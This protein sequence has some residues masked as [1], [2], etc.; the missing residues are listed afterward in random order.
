V[1]TRWLDE[2]GGPLPEGLD[3]YGFTGRLAKVDKEQS[4]AVNPDDTLSYIAHFSI[5]T[6]CKRQVFQVPDAS[7]LG[8]YYIHVNG[9]STY[10][11][12]RFA[13]QSLPKA[14]TDTDESP[15][16]QRPAR[17]VPFQVRTKTNGEYKTQ[18]RPEMEFSVYDIEVE[19][20]SVVE[21]GSDPE[22][23]YD[24]AVEVIYTIFD[25]AN[26][27]QLETFGGDRELVISVEDGG[28]EIIWP[29]EEGADPKTVW[30]EL[31]SALS[32]ED[33]QAIQIYQTGDEENILWEETLGGRIF[34]EK[35]NKAA[36]PPGDEAV[37]VSDFLPTKDYSDEVE[38]KIEKLS[39]GVIAKILPLTSGVGERFSKAELTVAEE[40][41][42]G[43]VKVTA[44]RWNDKAQTWVTAHKTIP[45]KCACTPC[46]KV[47][48][49]KESHV[50]SL[51][52]ELGLGN[53]TGGVSAGSIALEAESLSTDMDLRQLIRLKYQADNTKQLTG[54][55]EQTQQPYVKQVTSD[56]TFVDI[57]PID[58]NNVD[59]IF[60]E[61]EAR[62]D[63][64]NA[65]GVYETKA[66]ATPIKTWHVS[67]ASQGNTQYLTMT[68]ASGEGADNYVFSQSGTQTEP[69]WTLNKGNGKQVTTR[70]EVIVPGVSRTVTETIS[71]KSGAT[72]SVKIEK[73]EIFPW[74]ESIVETVE[75]PEGTAQKTTT[76]YC[77]A[78]DGQGCLYG[79][80]KHRINPDGSWV[81]YTYTAVNGR[82]DYGMKVMETSGLLDQDN[83]EANPS[84]VKAVSYDYTP[85]TD[86]EK[87]QDYK[88]R[89]RT[90]TV[91]EAG[92][93][94]SRTYYV[95]QGNPA[96]EH[97]EIVEQAWSPSAGYGDD[98]NQRTVRTYYPVNYED[99]S[100][101]SSGLLKSVQYPDGKMDTYRYQTEGEGRIETVTHGTATSP[102]GVPYKTT[103][104]VTTYDKYENAVRQETRVYTGNSYHALSWVVTAYDDAGRVLSTQQSDGLTTETEWGCCGKTYEMNA[105]GQ[106][107]TYEYD[108]LK[109]TVQ[110][111]SDRGT[112][113]ITTTYTLDAVGRQLA[114]KVTSGGLTQTTSNQYDQAGRL[115]STTGPDG[116]TTTYGYPDP[117]TTIVTRPGGAEEIT[118]RYI[119]GRTKSV[120]GTGVTPRYYE[121][122]TNADG[123]KTTTVYTGSENSP[124]WERTTTDM[125]GRTIKTEAPGYQGA[126]QVTE[127]FYDDKGRLV[128]TTAP[129]SA[130]TIYEYDELGN[131]TGGGLDV[132]GDQNLTEN[133][134][135]RL[136]RTDTMYVQMAGAWWQ[137]TV[138]AVYDDDN[139]E[140]IT[141]VQRARMSG[142]TGGLVSET[143]SV[144]IFGNETST[145]KYVSQATKTEQT[146][147][148]YPDSIVDATSTTEACSPQAQARPGSRRHL[149]TTP[150]VV[151]RQSQ[152]QEPEPQRP[153]TI[154]KDNSP[155]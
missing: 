91:T 92:Q 15:L 62:S 151:E 146:I 63:D 41:E 140:I 79:Q 141:G 145:R 35:K 136:S 105:N 16:E 39:K 56:Q 116:L 25:D 108:E 102:K 26:N 117:L 101:P 53:T 121:Y 24:N 74:G 59:I 80:V 19:E 103:Q 10:E 31:M 122:A 130:D 81:K 70:Q 22:S 106:E 29:P 96:L 17:F 124:V 45:V 154:P 7:S 138:G 113:R 42:N 6:G 69:T 137:E 86:D 1:H 149:D 14:E 54:E 132:S 152:I 139:K 57:K 4:N 99:R 21:N 23:P 82:D 111:V 115:E 90:V 87:L 76:E 9:S 27:E 72:A 48:N 131:R 100:D 2:D 93:V 119:D 3:A 107:S 150:L 73:Y 104:E 85:L 20:T 8:H 109:R 118:T 78:T 129:G 155:Q 13:I 12:Y 143:Q 38:W 44:K 95:Y 126:V 43:D 50:K 64:L 110:T 52:F 30:L 71:D 84:S 127:N 147:T 66:D 88:Q 77:L 49:A 68:E 128:R 123:T 60:Y 32:A 5:T 36:V 33:L 142:F 58:N 153:N 37:L 75:D 34:F 51:H 46:S 28:K 65:Q 134:D 18:V 135:D 125:L 89:P 133:S 67:H 97:K 61:R 112:G 40:S 120:T 55:N 114:S 98:N 94:V 47:A 148:E 144:D 83:P 11:N